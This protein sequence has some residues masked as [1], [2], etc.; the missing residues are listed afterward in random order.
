LFSLWCYLSRVKPNQGI[1]KSAQNAWIVGSIVGL[2]FGPPAALDLLQ[3]YF[4]DTVY[5]NSYSL[6]PVPR[7]LFPTSARSLLF[8]GVFG[9]GMACIQHF[10]LRLMLYRMGYIP[11]NYALFLNYAVE[12]LFMQKVG[13]DY[14]FVHRMLMEHFAQMELEQRQH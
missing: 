2:I 3:K 7:S 12:C 14:I 10:T 1:W 4:F 5:V 11:W 8:G 9:G 6:F 13:G